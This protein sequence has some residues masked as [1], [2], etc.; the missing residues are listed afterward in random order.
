MV[1]N[2][3]RAFMKR[4]LPIPAARQLN[5]SKPENIIQPPSVLLKQINVYM[6]L[7]RGIEN[8]GMLYL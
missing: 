5:P 6:S 1:A 4:V 7:L 8:Y 3:L 2:L